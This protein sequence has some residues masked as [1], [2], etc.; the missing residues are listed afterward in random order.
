MALEIFTLRIDGKQLGGDPETTA[1][2]ILRIQGQ[3]AIVDEAAHKII[4]PLKGADTGLRISLPY[5]IDLPTDVAAASP[6]TSEL[7]GYY[8]DVRTDAGGRIEAAFAAAAADSTVNLD[9]V[10]EM[11]VTPVSDQARLRNETEAF[12]DEAEDF[13]DEALAIAGRVLVVD[14]GDGTLDITTNG[15]GFTLEDNG[16]GTADLTL[17]GTTVTVGNPA[18]VLLATNNLSDVGSAA[19]ARANLGLGDAALADSADFDTA[20]AAAAR[21]AKASNLSD[22]TD[23]GAARDNLGLGT[24]AV[25]A[26]G[27]FVTTSQ[28]GAASGV[29]PLGVDTKLAE[30]YLPATT[31]LI[32]S[33]GADVDL[34]ATGTE[35]TVF[36]IT[37]PVGKWRLSA[38]VCVQVP[39]ASTSALTLMRVVADTATCT[40][41]GKASD[42]KFSASNATVGN[43]VSGPRIDVVITV[44]VAGDVKIKCRSSAANALAKKETPQQTWGQASAYIAQKLR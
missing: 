38:D 41:E 3:S 9:D 37:L 36:T 23:A 10:T 19:A 7:L 30:T 4:F 35:T 1:T 22:L 25:H 24:A 43:Q 8:V 33:L 2:L 16:D 6:D 34:G 44:T 15:G 28:V 40:I 26:T 17:E 31:L 21:L 11:I 32:A 29:A 27:D 13:R 12:R 5:T 39:T 42:E 18:D 14:N 20:G